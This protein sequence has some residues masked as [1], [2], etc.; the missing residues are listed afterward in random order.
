MS[1]ALTTRPASGEVNAAPWASAKLQ[2]HHLRR[3]AIVYVRQSS[4]HQVQENRE[5]TARQYALAG[6]AAQ[7]GWAAIQ[8]EVIDE[9]QGRSGATAEGRL[10][11]QRLLAEVSLDHVGIVLG[12]EMSR[13]ARSNKDWH[14][15]LELCAIF[16]TLLAD[17]DGLYDPTDYN[18]RLLLGLKGTMSEAELHILQGR[19]HQALLNKARR[20]D[21]CMLPPV[22]YIKR[23]TGVFALDPD[24]Q[25]QG[26]IRLIFDEFD[27]LGSMRRVL[28]HLHEQDIK[29]PI[30]PHAGPNKGDLEWRRATRDTI[31]TVLMHPLYSG[32]YRYGHRQ[33]DARR[34]KAGHRQ[35]GRVVVKPDQYHALIPGR[36]PAYITRER[37]ERHQQR[38]R[39]NRIRLQ[40]KGPPRNG[41]ALLGGILFCGRCQ[42]RMGVH[43]SGLAKLPRYLCRGDGDNAVAPACQCLSGRVLDQLVTEK[44]LQ[45]LEPAALEL[46]LLA[47]DDLHQQRQRL[48]QN[49]RQRLERAHYQAERAQRH[50]RAVE[51]EN[52]LVARELARQWEEALKEQ[53]ELEQQHARFSQ[54]HP[55]TLSEQERQRI[56]AL[57]QNLPAIWRAASTAPSD[58]QRIV[59]L[60]VDRVII[61]VQGNTDHVD[62]T[63]EWSG[64]FTSHHELIRPVL[65]YRQM[66]DYDR[67]AGRM[68]E[69]RGQGRTFAEIAQ[70][71][72]EEG[73]RPIR[74][75]ERFHK[76]LVC[77][78]FNKLCKERPTARHIAEQA[79][80]QQHEWF[81]MDL[82][83]RLR[84]PKNSLLHW[85]RRGWVHVVRQLPGYRGR[86]I[87]WAD[88]QEMDRLQRLRATAHHW[89]DDPLPDE[90]TTP[91]IRSVE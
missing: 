80:L 53:A 40:A 88:E 51:P 19:M 26:V 43:Y 82:A 90:L 16:R 71:L 6:R 21:L 14:Q 89:W 76:D 1:S 61:A 5:S 72:N 27:R 54:A 81:A 73:F 57:S 62:V 31:R 34:K 84:M 60:L 67:V 58:R 42:R 78:L 44:I 47:A 65:R 48:D 45:A 85:V 12:I 63:I 38:I 28:R 10:G 68:E 25:A 37:Y 39:E 11:F 77:R 52:R 69:L 2:D 50:Y 17:Q 70:R 36:C 87:C 56:R 55:A 91:M 49:W 74:Q 8:V 41:E 20:G 66:A 15:L 59:R 64:G 46:S 22:G 7:L 3:S 9:D 4:A 35:S 75:A 23:L 24:E 86:V 83:A 29:V 18:D 79:Q 33:T 32:T 30:R 13:L